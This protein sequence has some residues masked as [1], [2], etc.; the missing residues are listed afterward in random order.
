MMSTHIGYPCSRRQNAF[1]NIEDRSG[2]ISDTKN[3]ESLGFV[4]QRMNQ[5]QGRTYFTAVAVG[6]LQQ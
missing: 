3:L 6:Y 2:P 4:H 5:S 1:R